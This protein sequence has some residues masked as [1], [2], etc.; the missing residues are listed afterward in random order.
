MLSPGNARVFWQSENTHGVS[1]NSFLGWDHF[2]LIGQGVHVHRP[3]I[4]SGLVLIIHPDQAV[5]QPVLV[6]ALAVV[7][8]G[9]GAPAFGARSE[10]HTSELQSRG[11]LVCR[12][13]PD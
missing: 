4:D 7:F 5:L 8:T 11:H 9:M 1:V 12:L 3:V 2:D 10:E 13:L 6:I